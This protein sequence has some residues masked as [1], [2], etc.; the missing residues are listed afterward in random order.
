MLEDRGQTRGGDQPPRWPLMITDTCYSHPFMLP[1]Q[2]GPRLVCVVNSIWQIRWS[3]IPGIRIQKPTN[4]ESF[5]QVS[6][7]IWI[8]SFREASCHYEQPNGKTPQRGMWFR[9]EVGSSPSSLRLAQTQLAA[10]K[11]TPI[12]SHS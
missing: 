12:Q 11:E 8:T 4:K 7:L 3:T 10:S 1:S 5:C 6:S 2:T 9:L